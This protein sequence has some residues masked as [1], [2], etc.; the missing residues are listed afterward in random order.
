M[1][2]RLVFVVMATTIGATMIGAVLAG[3]I[4]QAQAPQA[5]AP[6]APTAEAPVPAPEPPS[7]PPRLDGTGGVLQSG[8]VDQADVGDTAVPARSYQMTCVVS[9]G[10]CMIDADAPGQRCH[11]NDVGHNKRYWGVTVDH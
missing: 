9:I 7:T 1:R 6:E 2:N 8:H 3:D 4:A 10:S 5:Q 11:C